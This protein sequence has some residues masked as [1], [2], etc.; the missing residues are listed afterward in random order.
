MADR[1]PSIES[2]EGDVWLQQ[3]ASVNRAFDERLGGTGEGDT[4]FIRRD[5][6]GI[7]AVKGE[8]TVTFVSTG[9]DRYIW[10]FELCHS[11]DVSP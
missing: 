11:L 5:V 8:N 9:L 3:Q 2:V 1:S 4:G 10:P 7:D 6:A